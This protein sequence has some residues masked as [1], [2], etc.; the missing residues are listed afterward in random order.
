MP[1]VGFESTII[2]SEW[3]QTDAF[4]LRSNWDR[5]VVILAYILLLQVN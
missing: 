1:P 5:Y 2:A 3:P 4:Y